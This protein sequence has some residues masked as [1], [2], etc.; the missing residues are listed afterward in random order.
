MSVLISPYCTNTSYIGSGPTPAT[1]F[2]LSWLFKGFPKQSHSELLEVKTSTY[3]LWEW[4]GD[5]IQPKT[6][7]SSTDLHEDTELEEQIIAVCPVP[8]WF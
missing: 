8:S 5:T 2:K 4:A 6:E 1:S 7:I 3:K